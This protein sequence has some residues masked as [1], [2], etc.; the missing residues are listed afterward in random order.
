MHTSLTLKSGKRDTA[1]QWAK[2]I[3]ALQGA[4]TG[5]IHVEAIAE[6]GIYPITVHL[7]VMPKTDAAH[8]ATHL[9]LSTHWGQAGNARYEPFVQETEQK[10][11]AEVKAIAKGENP[12]GRML[13]RITGALDQDGERTE[14]RSSVEPFVPS[15][16]DG[17]P[18]GR[19]IARHF[20]LTKSLARKAYPYLPEEGGFSKE[21]YGRICLLQFTKNLLNTG[22]LKE[23]EIS[24]ATHIYDIFQA[25]EEDRKYTG[26]DLVALDP[27]K[28]STAHY[29]IALTPQHAAMH[30]D[31]DW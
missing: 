27:S 21:I 5:P 3:S 9:F 30:A 8:A 16:V 6:T 31:P 2:A 25:M 23:D 18:V 17:T 26:K 28:S 24:H 11:L 22:R 12:V 20:G 15:Y 19:A 14:P 4:V 10:I 29:T 13:G 1:A 7:D